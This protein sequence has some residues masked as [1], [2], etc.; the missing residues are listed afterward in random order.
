M[1]HKFHYRVQ[2]SPSLV[3]MLNQM[4][5]FHTFPQCLL[6][7]SIPILSSHLRLDLPSSLP[8]RFSDQ[9]FLCMYHLFHACYITRPSHPSWFDHP[10]NIWWSVQVNEVPH[11]AVFST[12]SVY[13][14]VN[15]DSKMFLC[16][17][18]T[19]RT[20]PHIPQT[21]HQQTSHFYSYSTLL[22]LKTPFWVLFLEAHK[23]NA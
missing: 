16:L 18:V 5:P 19:V 7:R 10:N 12:P 11:H 21:I 1:E 9:N 8:F 23:V 17:H 6:L 15:T 14:A 3:P 2:N 22:S 13:V 4:N 20:F